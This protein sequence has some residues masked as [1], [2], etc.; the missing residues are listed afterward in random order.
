MLPGLTNSSRYLLAVKLWS[1]GQPAS[2]SAAGF[3][4]C[5]ESREEVDSVRSEVLVLSIGI[6]ECER[7]VHLLAEVAPCRHVRSVSYADR[8]SATSAAVF[9]RPRAHDSPVPTMYTLRSRLG[10]GGTTRS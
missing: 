10:T 9:G 2:E 8:T 3:D 6:R 5:L 4:V 7:R 1:I